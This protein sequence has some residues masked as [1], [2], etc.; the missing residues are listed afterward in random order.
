MTTRLARQ[1]IL[2][3]FVPRHGILECLKTGDPFEIGKTIFWSS[4]QCLNIMSTIRELGFEND[5]SVSSELV[6]Y[7]AINTEFDTIK[8]LA[9]ENANLKEEMASLKKDLQS[10]IK[11]ASTL[12]NKVDNVKVQVDNQSK[13]LKTLEKP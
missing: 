12:A 1:L 10:A 9:V 8:K 7:L 2:K 3:T 13:R 6:K 11:T 4:L 5:T